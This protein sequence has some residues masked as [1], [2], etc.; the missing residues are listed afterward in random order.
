M[1]TIKVIQLDSKDNVVYVSKEGL[2]NKEQ[3][4]K[5]CEQIKV[6]SGNNI[7]DL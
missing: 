3:I 7:L 5:E 4:K 2:K 6:L 1:K